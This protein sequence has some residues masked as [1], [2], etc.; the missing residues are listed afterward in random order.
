M[1]LHC[2]MKCV[3]N[4][5]YSIDGIG[6]MGCEMFSYL[7]EKFSRITVIT[8]LIAFGFGWQ[9]IYE[10]SKDVKNKIQIIYMLVLVMS[11]YEDLQL[12]QWIEEHPSDLFHLL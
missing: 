1:V 7:L 9:V 12:S 8:I 2:V 6:S 3:H 4:F 10:N 5:Y 11:V